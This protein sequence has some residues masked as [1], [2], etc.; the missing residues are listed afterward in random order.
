VVGLA[1]KDYIVDKLRLTYDGLFSVRELYNLVTEWFE[2]R[3]YDKNEKK[4]FEAV[5]ADGRNIEIWME[6]WRTLHSYVKRFMRVR[7]LMSKVKD[8]EVEK[9]GV[10]LKLNQGKVQIVFDA[11]MQTD[12]ESEWEGKPFYFFIR[13]TFNKFFFRPLTSGYEADLKGE[14]NALYGRVKS[15]LNMQ[16]YN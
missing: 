14:V 8:V 7:I 4:N 9:D 15:Y 10:K 3:G 12:L 11:W 5:D 13:T 6:P 2:E 1:E 16:R